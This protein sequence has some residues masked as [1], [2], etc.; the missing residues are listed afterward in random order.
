MVTF[1]GQPAAVWEFVYRSEGVLV[2]ARELHVAAGNIHY[3]VNV[4]SPQT[5]WDRR[6]RI[7]DRIQ[8]SFQ[9]PDG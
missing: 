8:E 4:R 1:K 6:S 5:T 2:H 3:I 7:L 9:V